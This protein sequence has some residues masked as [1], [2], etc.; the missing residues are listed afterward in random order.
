MIILPSILEYS[1]ETLE[2][3]LDYIDTNRPELALLQAG[4]MVPHLHLDFVLP[5]FSKDRRVMTSHQP[6]TVLGAIESKFDPKKPLNLDL[7]LMGAVEDLFEQFSFFE[8][9]NFNS[10]W[11]FTLFLPQKYTQSWQSMI[12]SRNL[13]NIKIGTW[14]DLGQW[15]DMSK[16]DP[17][18]QN[19]C[20]EEV[21]TIPQHFPEFQKG[22]RYL[23]M[24]VVAGKSGQKLTD[25]VAK[26]VLQI[27]NDNPQSSFVLDGGWKPGAIQN[28]PIN[29]AFVSYSGFW[30]TRLVDKYK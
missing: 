16:I 17:Q 11:T 3:K 2:Q 12:E 15:A 28:A 22:Q 23:L 5:Q 14:F 21:L 7:H 6:A 20:E 25:A 18:W 4:S 1:L 30:G 10:N 24:T 26:K 9:Y 27:V 13:K 29:S 19:P 8:S